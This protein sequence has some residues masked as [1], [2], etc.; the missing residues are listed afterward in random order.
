MPHEWATRQSEL[1]CCER[2][3]LRVHSRRA[4]DA[5]G[6]QECPGLPVK[7]AAVLANPS[8]H[9]LVATCDSQSRC[10]LACTVCGCWA[11]V[12][13]RRLL[14]K[15]GGAA[16][17]RSEG[18]KAIRR[19]A[20]GEHPQQD[21]GRLDGPVLAVGASQ[22]AFAPAAVRDTGACGSSVGTTPAVGVEEQA[23]AVNRLEALRLRVLA[24][25]GVA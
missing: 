5:L 13:H 23:P 16:P 10:I 9:V 18:Y 22:Q 25:Q 1:W 11:H 21:K 12:V 6:H 24:K 8:G 20:L 17:A 4:A 7:L 15:Y 3:Y 19:L 14:K 2:R